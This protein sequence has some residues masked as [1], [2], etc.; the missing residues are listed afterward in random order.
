M[1]NLQKRYK[2]GII[3]KKKS[4]KV[5]LSYDCFAKIV[6]SNLPNCN[7]FIPLQREKMQKKQLL[8]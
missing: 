2:Y 3:L 4:I 7:F 5:A 1:Q 8:I 6:N